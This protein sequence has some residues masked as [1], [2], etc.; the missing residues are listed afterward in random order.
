MVIRVLVLLHSRRHHAI[1]IGARQQSGKGKL[2]LAVF[3]FVVSS[4][5]CLHLLEQTVI[6]KCRMGS[7]V[8]LSR[9]CEISAIK[10]IPQHLV[11]IAFAESHSGFGVNGLSQLCNRTVSGGIEFKDALCDTG[12]YRVKLNLLL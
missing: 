2:M 9:P 4:K 5:D 1:V 11:K 7:F 3:G 6:D 12:F 8:A 10:L